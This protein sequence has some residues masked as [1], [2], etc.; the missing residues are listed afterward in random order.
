MQNKHS[1]ARYF[2]LLLII[3]I[4]FSPIPVLYA[5]NSPNYDYSLVPN[6]YSFNRDFGNP[7]QD[8]A[9]QNDVSYLQCILGMSPTGYFGS[10]TQATLKTFQENHAEAVLTPVGLTT[11]TGY[12]GSSTRAYI[13]AQLVTDGS[14]TGPHCSA[15]TNTTDQYGNP[16]GTQ[17]PN[18]TNPYQTNPNNNNQPANSQNSLLPLLPY[19]MMMSQGGGAPHL[20]NPNQQNSTNNQTPY[21]PPT[22]TTTTN[23]PAGPANPAN[24]VNP[25]NPQQNPLANNY[26][27]PLS[28]QSPNT[29]N[30]AT[31]KCVTPDGCNLPQVFNFPMGKC[32]DPSGTSQTPPTSSQSNPDHIFAGPVVYDSMDAVNRGNE[33][34]LGND[35][36]PCRRSEPHMF[37]IIVNNRYISSGD[38]SLYLLFDENQTKLGGQLVASQNNLAPAA[39]L[40]KTGQCITGDFIPNS[41]RLNGY[42]SN[43]CQ[44]YTRYGQPRVGSTAWPVD[45]ILNNIEVSANGAC[46]TNVPH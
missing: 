34:Y 1:L 26:G 2:S 22:T 18:N 8:P 17:Y 5:Q 36:R 25:A 38:G 41:T 45:G 46:S 4:F 10:I 9:G 14:T 42:Q 23:P 27:N 40:L 43:F 20:V 29:F 28:C 13:N 33:I 30:Y 16:I 35:D 11:G 12:L 44:D 15:P 39:E 7:T 24:P 21:Y 31:G 3:G 32:V 37:L 19:F 6:T